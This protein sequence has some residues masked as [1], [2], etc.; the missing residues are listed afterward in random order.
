[1]AHGCASADGFLQDAWHG[2][3]EHWE[4]ERVVTVFS[5]FHPLLANHRLLES[6]AR[7]EFGT[8]AGLGLRA[9]GHT[10]SIDLTG[11]QSGGGKAAGLAWPK[12]I[13]YDIRRAR[14][15]GITTETNC[16]W[17]N[18]AEFVRL[19]HLAMNRNR[20]AAKYYFG[21]T[22]FHGLRRALA[23][24]VFLHVGRLDNKIIA[25]AVTSE[26]AGI[27]QYL[28]SGD[29]EELR[30]VSTLKVL[31]TDIAEWAQGRGNYSFHLGG[32]RGA[33]DRDSLFFFKSRFSPGRHTF[34]TGRWILDSAAYAM[35]CGHTARRGTQDNS[36]FFPAYRAPEALL[37]QHPTLVASPVGL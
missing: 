17:D 22:Y 25:A 33:Q 5:R 30:E 12:H 14:A 15:L 34:H 4:S 20:A 24:R 26:Y 36:G 2:L 6:S 31:L 23:G 29:D 28:F 1:L 13:R 32:G 21:E 37:S 10:V 35:L 19:Y 16:S 3:L 8:M 18:L 9:E 27:A 11:C 7:P